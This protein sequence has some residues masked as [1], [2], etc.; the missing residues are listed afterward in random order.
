[1]PVYLSSQHFS[2]L[3]TYGGWIVIAVLLLG[4]VLYLDITKGQKR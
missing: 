2:A 3:Q 1:M 4:C